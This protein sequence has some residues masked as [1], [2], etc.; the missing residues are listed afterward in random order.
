[1]SGDKQ[2]AAAG[3]IQRGKF[4]IIIVVIG[5]VIKPYRFQRIHNRVAGHK[6]ALVWH[7]LTQQIRS[8]S[9][10][11]S[12]VKVSEAAREPSVDLLWKWLPSIERPEPRLNVADPNAFVES[13]Q[14]RCCYSGCVTLYKNGVWLQL[15]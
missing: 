5:I 6:D 10:S 13:C 2:D 3:L 14:R 12:K 8:G 1:M 9:L 11:R 15:G 4:G 7:A